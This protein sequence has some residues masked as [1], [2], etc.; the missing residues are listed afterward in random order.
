MVLYLMTDGG[1]GSGIDVSAASPREWLGLLVSVP[2]GL[3]LY[4]FLNCWWVGTLLSAEDRSI[5]SIQDLGAVLIGGLRVIRRS[6]LVTTP[7][8]FL[9]WFIVFGSVSSLVAVTIAFVGSLASRSGESISGSSVPVAVV[10][11]VVNAWMIWGAVAGTVFSIWRGADIRA[12]K[13]P[14]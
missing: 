7:L 12:L 13:Q 9:G 14:A 1:V 11:G 10:M 3:C 2:L 8:A 4:L 5:R 6:G